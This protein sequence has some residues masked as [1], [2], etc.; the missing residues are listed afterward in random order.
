MKFVEKDSILQANNN[1]IQINENIIQEKNNIM[2]IKDNIII[3]I[4]KKER[5][6]NEQNMCHIFKDLIDKISLS[7]GNQYKKI[8]LSHR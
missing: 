4:K 1:I 3:I 8:I 5:K 7:Y 6:R 2:L